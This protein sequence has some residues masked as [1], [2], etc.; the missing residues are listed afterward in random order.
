[1]R[2]VVTAILI[3]VI[4]ALSGCG[5]VSGNYPVPKKRPPQ[6]PEQYEVQGESKPVVWERPGEVRVFALGWRNVAQT[7]PMLRNAVNAGQQQAEPA[8]KFFEPLAENDKV[9]Y[10]VAAFVHK[11]ATMQIP[12]GRIEIS[13]A[14]GESVTDQGA[15]FVEQNKGQI[16]FRDSRNKTLKVE[17]KYATEPGKPV[18]VSFIVDAEHLDKNV[19]AV[20]YVR[21]R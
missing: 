15:F 3:T 21:G 7:V 13:F 12:L 1:M 10:S 4:V 11:S 8:L 20:R 19:T 5:H 17:S 2:L 9:V 18:V 14:D 16:R 6:L